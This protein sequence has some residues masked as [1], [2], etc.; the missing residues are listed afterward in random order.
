MLCKACNKKQATKG[1]LCDE[2]ED[3][4]MLSASCDRIFRGTGLTWS[5]VERYSQENWINIVNKTKGDA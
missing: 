5:N 4:R 3:N 2:C 1:I